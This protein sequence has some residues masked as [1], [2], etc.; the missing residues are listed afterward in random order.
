MQPPLREPRGPNP[1]VAPAGGPTILKPKL[2][3]HFNGSADRV[4]YFI[5]CVTDFLQ[6]WGDL[7]PDDAGQAAYIATR[8]VCVSA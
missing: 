2:E 8:L 1:P 6:L 7:F 3:A 5:V 4:S